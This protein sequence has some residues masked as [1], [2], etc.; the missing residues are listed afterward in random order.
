MTAGSLSSVPNKTRFESSVRS[1]RTHIWHYMLLCPAAEFSA[2][3]I[4]RGG[5]RKGYFLLSRVGIQVRIA[6]IYVDSEDPADW[7]TAFSL[8]TGAAAEDS[9]V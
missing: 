8:A 6:D 7:N 9:R 1:T 4:H 5:R 3:Q 2:F